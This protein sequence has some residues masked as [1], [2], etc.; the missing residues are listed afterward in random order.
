[1]LNTI[2]DLKPVNLDATI[3]YI[4]FFCYID[5]IKIQNQQINFA[6]LLLCH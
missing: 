4:A 2:F 6:D 3:F 1:M 5:N